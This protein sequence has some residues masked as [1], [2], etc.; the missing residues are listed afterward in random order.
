MDHSN[1]ISLSLGRASRLPPRTLPFTLQTQPFNISAETGVAGGLK[2]K[3]SDHV[4]DCA[5]GKEEENRKVTFYI[6]PEE[7]PDECRIR[8]EN[9]DGWCA[10]GLSRPSGRKVGA[11]SIKAFSAGVVAPTRTHTYK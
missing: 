8:D 6:F 2:K 11:D 4:C 1:Q 3:A 9:D 5:N 10:F 7:R